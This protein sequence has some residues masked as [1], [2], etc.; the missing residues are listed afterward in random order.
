VNKEYP[1]SRQDEFTRAL[2][3]LVSP[4]VHEMVRRMEPIS[5]VYPSR[6]TRNR[7]RHYEKWRRP[8]ARF[9]AVADA[10]CSYNPRYGQG[11]SAAAISAKILNDCVARYGVCDVHLVDRFFSEQARF[12][13]TPW[14][15]AAGDDLRFPVTSGSRSAS[16]WLFNWYRSK[17]AACSHRWSAGGLLK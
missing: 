16:V 3:N 11:M 14:L 10:A 7:W 8:L 9:I 2:A 12:Q 5:P 15:F 17:A 13:R 1:P 6:A 4:V